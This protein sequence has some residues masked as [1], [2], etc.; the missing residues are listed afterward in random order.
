MAGE[1][2]VFVVWD[3]ADP[4]GTNIGSYLYVRPFTNRSE[5][6]SL[7]RRIDCGN[8]FA[9]TITNLQES[10]AYRLFVTAYT[11]D[12][13]LESEKSNKIMFCPLSTQPG[14][15]ITINMDAFSG[16]TNSVFSLT[17]VYNA[18]PGTVVTNSKTIVYS[19]PASFRG[20]TT[21]NISWSEIHEFTNLCAYVSVVV[22]SGQWD[23]PTAPDQ[24]TISKQ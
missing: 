21:F 23:F 1:R 4:A 24:I 10:V 15:P 16:D 11:K 22:A 3:P 6:I 17:N 5:V 19:P 14:V 9:A 2:R 7:E 12:N 20:K 8:N 18:L 13:L